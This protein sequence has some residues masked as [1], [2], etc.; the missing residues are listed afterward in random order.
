MIE[1]EA[2]PA[3]EGDCLW[4]EYG[5]VS[6]RCRILIDGGRSHT[7]GHLKQ[8]IGAL[9]E[10][11]QRFELLVVTHIDRDHIEGALDLLEDAAPA[12]QFDEVW[13]NAYHHLFAANIETYSPVQG[14]RL[15]NCLKRHPGWNRAFDKKGVVL[16]DGGAKS[17]NLPGGATLHLISPDQDKLDRLRPLWLKTVTEAGLL[18]AEVGRPE[19][20]PGIEVLGALDIDQLAASPF[21]PDGSRPN[22]SSI[23]FVLAHDDKRVLFAGDA[24][25]DLLCRSIPK[26]PFF[27]SDRGRLAVDAFKLSHHGSAKN[28]SK[29][30]LELVDCPRYI[31]STNGN[32]FNH[33][34]RE[35]VAR[36]IKFGGDKPLLCFNYRSDETEIWDDDDLKRA[37]G[38]ETAYAPSGKGFALSLD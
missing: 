32:Y 20:R 33:P 26:L 17:V 9:R 27:D 25:V 4:I 1:I 38:Y 8:K 5:D 30:L 15:T 21:T 22:G 35:A 34:D 10:A 3:E 18:P 24:H 13:F 28:C 36:V 14:E 12:F 11:E 19:G 31:F 16:P 6:N 7:Y 23:A 37:H 2:L 29:E